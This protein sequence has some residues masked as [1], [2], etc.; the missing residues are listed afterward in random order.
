V[1][2][3]CNG[4]IIKPDGLHELTPC[5]FKETGIYKNVVIQILECPKCGNVSIGWYKTKDTVEC[6]SLEEALDE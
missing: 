1:S 2:C 5:K 4:F 6:K 3:Q